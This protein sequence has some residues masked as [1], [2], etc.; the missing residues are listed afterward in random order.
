MI[1]SFDVYLVMQ[2]DSILSV[3]FVIALIT[4]ILTTIGSIA[5]GLSSSFSE[6]D[7]EAKAFAAGI[8]KPLKLIVAVFTFTACGLALLPSSK[9]AAAMILVP[10]LTSEQVTAPL[11]AEAK[12]LYALAKQALVNVAQKP[13][14]P[15]KPEVEK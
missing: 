6:Q 8:K 12:E 11:T 2:L 9:T 5:F 15:P 7:D 10:A 3:M 13:D 4:G 1:S 14:D